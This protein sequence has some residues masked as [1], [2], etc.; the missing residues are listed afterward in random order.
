M[1]S[2]TRKST[3]GV[4]NYDAARD[5]VTSQLDALEAALNAHDK[6]HDEH[7]GNF[8]FVADLNEVAGL[9]ATAVALL[10]GTVRTGSEPR[11]D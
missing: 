11:N 9:L 4:A 2:S 8:G 10:K 3:T 7:L 6:M 1:N 5:Q